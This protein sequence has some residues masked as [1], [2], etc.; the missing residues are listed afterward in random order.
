M[1]QIWPLD[2]HN[3]NEIQMVL[4]VKEFIIHNPPRLVP[5]KQW[6]T[7]LAMGNLTLSNP[8]M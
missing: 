2:E 1:S 7:S 5:K 6:K 4:Y 8:K 3:G